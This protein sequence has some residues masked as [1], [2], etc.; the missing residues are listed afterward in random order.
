ML[1][2]TFLNS[3]VTKSLEFNLPCDLRG[4]EFLFG[5][6]IYINDIRDYVIRP[7]HVFG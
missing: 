6:V 2:F 7:L 3:Y 5:N 4:R 1:P